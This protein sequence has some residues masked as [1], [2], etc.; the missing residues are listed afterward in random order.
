MSVCCLR[1]VTEV[2]VLVERGGPLMNNLSSPETLP[3]PLSYGWFIHQRCSAP[4]LRDINYYGCLPEIKE[5]TR[6]KKQQPFIEDN[7]ELWHDQ[8]RPNWS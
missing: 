2:L 8:T 1:E 6:G 4:K 5:V 7:F 3:G